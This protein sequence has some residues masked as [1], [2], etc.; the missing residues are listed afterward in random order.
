MAVKMPPVKKC[1]VQDCAYNTNMQ[2]VTPAITVG[3][4]AEPLCDTYFH[5]DRHGGMQGIQAGVG[6]CKVSNCQYNMDFECSAGG[7]EVG[8]KNDNPDCL[9]YR[10]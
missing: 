8:Y 1:S 10:S 9:T 2:C 5:S 4:T 6:A 7:I 3:D